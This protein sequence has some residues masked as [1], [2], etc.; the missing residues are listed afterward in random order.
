MYNVVI[1]SSQCWLFLRLKSERKRTS[2]V[3]PC[4]TKKQTKK[5][6]SQ[7]RT[8]SHTQSHT[9]QDLSKSRSQSFFLLNGDSE[10]PMCRHPLGTASAKFH[11]KYCPVLRLKSTLYARVHHNTHTHAAP[12]SSPHPLVLYAFFNTLRCHLPDRNGCFNGPEISALNSLSVITSEISLWI[13]S[14]ICSIPITP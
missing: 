14:H 13:I 12:H 3:C 8:Q 6:H 1:H 9:Q 11:N 7:S 5:A 2:L 10:Q 4:K